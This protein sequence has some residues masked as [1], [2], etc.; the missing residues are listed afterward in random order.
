MFAIFK[1]CFWGFRGWGVVRCVKII[2]IINQRLW[3]GVDKLSSFEVIS[4]T[5]RRHKSFANLTDFIISLNCLLGYSKD[6]THAL[7]KHTLTVQKVL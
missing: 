5:T 3:Y 7:S 4:K 6:E 1:Y 2:D